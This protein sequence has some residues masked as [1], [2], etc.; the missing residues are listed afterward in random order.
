[1]DYKTLV[2]VLA[3]HESAIQSVANLTREIGTALQRCPISRRVVDFRLEHAD[4]SDLFDERGRTKTHLWH[5]LSSHGVE[6]GDD[7]IVRRYL[8]APETGCAHCEQAFELI[9]QRR[10]SRRELGIAKRMIR[11][12]GKKAMKLE[13]R[14]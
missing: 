4:T 9:L 7:E 10:K 8:A 2:S 14:Q 1:M 5:A 11:H 6:H 3:R 13:A 12:Y